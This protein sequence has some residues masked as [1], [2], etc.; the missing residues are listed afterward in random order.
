MH[1]TL[2]A[3]AQRRQTVL[4]LR[5]P[6]QYTAAL[7]ALRAQGDTGRD[8]LAVLLK[9]PRTDVRAMAAAFLLRYRPAEAKAV[10]EATANEGGVAAIGAIMTLRRWKDGTWALDPE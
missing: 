8:A 10:L 2:R 1:A 9:H 6:K 7:Q 3:P 4:V 5:I